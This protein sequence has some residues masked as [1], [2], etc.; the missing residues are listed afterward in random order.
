MVAPF[1]NALAIKEPNAAGGAGQ[2]QSFERVFPK[3]RY[4]LVSV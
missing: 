3:P 1:G 4:F 2:P